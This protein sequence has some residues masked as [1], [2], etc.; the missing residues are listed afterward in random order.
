MHGRVR[1]EIKKR[2]GELRLKQ[3]VLKARVKDKIKKRIAQIKDSEWDF[4]REF[5]RK[6]IHLLS[7]FFILLYFGTA[8]FFGHKAGLLVLAGL[9]IV[10]LEIEYVRIELKA[11]LPILSYLWKH[12]RR[13]SEHQ[14][15]GGEI[16][17]LLGAIIVFAVFDERI[18]TVALLMTTFGDLTA[19]LVGKYVH[20]IWIFEK[21]KKALEGALAQFL[22]DVFV[23]FIFL[24]TLVNGKV[25]WLS[26]FAI[27]GDPLWGPILIMAFAATFVET[28]V[29]KIDDNLLIPLFSGFAGHAALVFLGHIVFLV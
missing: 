26:G 15:V 22:V 27:V 1:G 9:L 28:C 11:K 19:A 4:S 29:S 23:G 20:N 7:L 18:A 8:H 21:K 17:F 3:S 16:F 6:L 2:F 13:R 14:R 12:F 24:R 10:L 5:G 25:W